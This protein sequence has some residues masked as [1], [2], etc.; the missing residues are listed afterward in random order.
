MELV[1]GTLKDAHAELLLQGAAIVLP[2]VKRQPKSKS[3]RLGE[4][5]RVTKTVRTSEFDGSV[6]VRYTVEARGNTYRLH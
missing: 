3:V 4:I 1:V 5:S 2:F 6:S